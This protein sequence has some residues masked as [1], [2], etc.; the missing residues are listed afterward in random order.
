M[1]DRFGPYL[2]LLGLA[3]AIVGIAKG[4]DGFPRLPPPP[5]ESEP[6]TEPAPIAAEGDGTPVAADLTLG[7]LQAL[8]LQW[9]PTLEQSRAEIQRAQGNRLQAGL[10]PNP[11]VGYT[12]SDIGLEGSAGQQGVFVQQ[13]F[14]TGGKLCLSR[15][16]FAADGQRAQWLAAEQELRVVND[17]RRAYYEVLVARRLV[18]IARE[19][20]ELSEDV[21]NRTRER[22]EGEEGTRID[23]LQARIALQQTELF[24][25]TTDRRHVA[26]WR[27]L[28]AI[29]G[30]EVA[31]SSL[32]GDLEE[33]VPDLVFSES[34]GRLLSTSPRL[35]RAR[36]AVDRSRAAI[37]RARV[38]PTPNVTVQASTAYD[39]STNDQIV[40]LQVGVP[41]PVHDRNQGNVH[42]ASA[43]CIRATRE[44]ARLELD[45]RRGL[46]ESFRAY[47]VARARTTKYRDDILPTTDETL[48]LSREAYEAGEL[49][50]LQLLA[51]QR[52]Y[53]GAKR[54]YV[55]SLGEFW[56][57]VVSIDGL[58]L[59]G[60]LTAPP[61]IGGP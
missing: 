30:T 43:E 50:Y 19:L 3:L 25:E 12:A 11:I 40:G 48:T 37:V 4:D 9:N 36:A 13:E 29:V 8:A 15:R 59:D 60:G 61:R 32:V 33:N 39:F 23:L 22:F 28:Q 26:A 45:L 1:R 55:E 31:M 46:A 47:D 38:Q 58:L 14:V 2:V 35:A 57:A 10:Y 42:A 27:R 21:A 17:V 44:V 7:D 24:A 20:V 52:D 16:I 18:A 6:S 53:V 54:M 49:S 5:V 41:L 34:Y 51:V 56:D